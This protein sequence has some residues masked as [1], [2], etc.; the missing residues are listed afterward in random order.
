[1]KRIILAAGCFAMLATTACKNNNDQEANE[2]DQAM[3]TDTTAQTTKEEWKDLFNG[4]NLEGWKAYNKDSISSQWR[5]EDGALV[6]TPAEERNG[7]E[8]L[9]SKEEFENFELKID[10]KISEGGNSGI[11]WAVQED[12][13]YGEP[14]LT[15]PE[16]QVLDD[17]RH[18]DAKNGPNR[19]S[20]SL[21][22][23]VPPAKNVV[24]PAG[25]WNQ[26]VIH[27]DHQKNEGW[28]EL[29]GERIVEFPVNGEGW[30]ELVQN[31]KFA[32]WDAFA[33]ETK[34]HLA[35]QDHGHAVSFKNIK[36]KEL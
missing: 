28:V 3:V 2:R 14:Y 36:I 12:E 30:N 18:P 24:N 10:W 35:L 26:E 9:I 8:N 17:E 31:S 34:G 29:N 15:G 25:V 7:A 11:M 27:I 33:K 1:M 20:G 4:E 5:V 22:D 32:S 16:I 21:Y 13:K 23:M 6:F 19:L